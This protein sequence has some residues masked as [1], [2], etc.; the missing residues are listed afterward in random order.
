MHMSNYFTESSFV[1]KKGYCLN[2]KLMFPYHS[3]S[4]RTNEVQFHSY[5]HDHFES[6]NQCFCQGDSSNDNSMVIN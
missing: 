2:K 4:L 1:H 6:I 3:R 5:S